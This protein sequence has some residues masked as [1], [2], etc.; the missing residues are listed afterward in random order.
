[1]ND[2][3]KPKKQEL[4]FRQQLIVMP[5]VFLILALTFNWLLKPSPPKPY[6]PPTEQETAKEVFRNVE[7]YFKQNLKNPDSYKKID[8]QYTKIK[9]DANASGT[10]EWIFLLTYEATNS[11]NAVI[12]S[13]AKIRAWSGGGQVRFNILQ[14]E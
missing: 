10:S 3:N 12:R 7:Y 4:T 6:V 9:Y 13:R 8:M 2:E 5:F 1:M 14:N 11:F